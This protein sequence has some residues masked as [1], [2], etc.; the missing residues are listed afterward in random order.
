M[1]DTATVLPQ[2]GLERMSVEA[3]VRN[4]QLQKAVVGRLKQENRL[5]LMNI[6]EEWM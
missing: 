3:T 1:L 6:R 2:L 4:V 5:C